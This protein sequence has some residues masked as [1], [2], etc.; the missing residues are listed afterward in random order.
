[1]RPHTIEAVPGLNDPE[2]TPFERFEK[3]ARM[4]VQVPK[5]EADRESKKEN[6]EIKRREPTGGR[7]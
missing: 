2:L 3:F 4:I 5:S 1:V 6:N 7:N